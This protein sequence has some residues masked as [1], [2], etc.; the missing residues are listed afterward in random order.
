M[1][2]SAVNDVE[3]RF[4]GMSRSG[5]HAV[6]NW[7]LRQ[8]PGR[9][10]FLNCTEGKSNPFATARPMD[11]GQVALTDIDELDLD[12]ERAGRHARKRHF[13]FSH[14]D[15]FLRNACSDKF[16]REHDQL[17][18]RSRRRI[19]LLLL[20]DPFNLF[21]S[22]LRAGTSKLSNTIAARM[23]KQHAREA[24]SARPRM[25]RNEPVIVLY[26]RW[27]TDAG[28]R[29]RIAEAL[30][31]PFSDAGIEDVQACLGG[32][33]FDGLH[34]HGR[35]SAMRV[36]DRWRHYAGDPALRAILDRQM[37]EMSDALFG[38]VDRGELMS[39]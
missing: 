1:A 17:V 8:A 23:W 6:I 31:L 7:I 14:E 20:R 29:R 28:H 13:L 38:P 2:T 9:Y 12:A 27:F 5:N 35:A 37:V 34:Y 19:D 11:D 32:S 22:R 15:N 21:A 4:I 16:E 18:G 33:S 25:L 36:L 3:V 39:R 24:L 10:C 30:E 26:N